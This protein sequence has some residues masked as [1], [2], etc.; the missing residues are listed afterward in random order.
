MVTKI[1]VARK[2]WLQEINDREQNPILRT[3]AIFKESHCLD[4]FNV[5]LLKNIS[6]Q[7]LVSGS[8]PTDLALNWGD[9]QCWKFPQVRRSEDNNFG[10]G[11]GTFCWFFFNFMFMI[12]DS[13]HEDLQLFW[14]S[15]QHWRHYKPRLPVVQRLCN[16]CNSRN[17]D[18]ELHF[19]IKCVFHTNARKTF[20]LVLDKN[21]S[22]FWK[23]TG[24]W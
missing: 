19:L 18:D 3:Y 6:K 9:T 5:Y 16:F 10:G 15:F 21:I 11:P 24:W 1:W 7:S 23:S 20:Y 8:V 13:R 12:C 17:L 4:T 14:L 2:N 22:K